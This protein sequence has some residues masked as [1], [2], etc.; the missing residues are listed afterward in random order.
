MPS[1]TVFSQ[2]LNLTYTPAIYTPCGQRS[3]VL[4]AQIDVKSSN[5]VRGPVR[6]GNDS[7]AG[8]EKWGVLSVLDVKVPCFATR[9]C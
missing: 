7:P 4:S 1:R 9:K 5:A 2:S 8:E 6:P 3:V